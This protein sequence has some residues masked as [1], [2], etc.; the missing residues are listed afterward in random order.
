LQPIFSAR[1]THGR[2]KRNPVAAADLDPRH[3]AFAFQEWHCV[4]SG[5]SGVLTVADGISARP[6]YDF[7]PPEAFFSHGAP[8]GANVFDVGD[9]GAV[10]DAGIDNQPMI[11]AAIDAAHAAGGGIVTIPPGTYGLGVHADGYG[12]LHLLDNVF[13]KGAGMG[14]TN[15]RLMD[16]LDETVTGI[17]R[18]PWSAVTSNWG[19]ADLTLD[20]NRANTTGQVDGFFTGPKPGL[21]AA[22]AD[23]YVLRVEIHDVSRYGFDPHEQTARLS[24]RDSVAHDNAVDGFVLDFTQDSELLGNVAYDNGRHGFNFVT[25]SNDILVN[26]NIAHDNGGAGFVI[27]RGSENI[28]APHGIALLGGASYGNAR[29]GVLVQMAED[30]LVSG[31]DIH[32]N[33]RNGV[34][35]LG[36]SHVTIENNAI[37]GNSQSLHDGYSEI[38]ITG[39][40]DPVYG[41]TYQADYNLVRGNTI[42]AT[43]LVQARYGIEERAGPAGYNVIQDNSVAGTVR[44]PIALN[45]VDS[46]ALKLG[47]DANDT[48]AGSSTQ[49]RILGGDGSDS[50]SG[51]DGNDL[52]EGGA[53]LDQLTGGKGNDIL[54]GGS[55]NDTLNGNSG[56]D[57]LAG[58]DGDDIVLGDAGN[59]RLAGGLGNDTLTAGSG[60]DVLVADAGTDRMDGGS[61]A[62]TADFSGIANAVT[63]DLTAKTA[64]GAGADTL[65]S[66]ERVVGTGYADTLKGDNNAN[67]LLGGD[68]DD[69]I[70]GMGG[71]DVL[72]GGA[73][74]DTFVWATAKDVVS[75]GVHLGLDHITDF[76]PGDKLDLHGLIGGQAYASLDDLVR[77]ADTAAG[78]IVS[79]KIAGVFQ[80]FVQLDGYHEDA[81]LDLVSAGALVV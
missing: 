49:D 74:G 4:P 44:G 1:Q 11:Q 39:L 30:I 76:G 81:A 13:L 45:G 69:S 64:S 60:D 41:T 22:D 68:G 12:S 63:V 35:V 15:L 54:L 66:I 38:D 79:V 16:G 65:V 55:G 50:L 2:S 43:G 73:G 20:G 37:H 32:D 24:I 3:V 6:L 21:T 57:A 25:T 77:V 56:D 47:T 52:L 14:E 34:R 42:E 51:Q 26:D 40:V 28:E 70:R 59:D 78:V 5:L 10:A 62:D 61:G 48:I 18:S 75:A 72:T 7:P 58:D 8:A 80:A 36:G 23:I 9:F 71:A 33:G 27:Q 46:Y 53:G 19:V 17:I 31:L 29:E 67:T